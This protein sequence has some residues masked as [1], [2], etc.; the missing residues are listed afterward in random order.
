MTMLFFAALSVSCSEIYDNIKEFSVEEIVYPAHYDTIF[1]RPGY[2]R[3]EIDL[4]KEGRLPSWMMKLGKATKTIIEYDTVSLRYDSL[5]SW[6]N[7]TGLTQPKLYRFRIYTTDDNFEDRS[8]PL[9]IDIAPYSSFDRDALAV[10]TPNITTKSDFVA[11]NWNGGLTSEVME[12]RGLIYSYADKNGDSVNVRKWVE[13]EFYLTGLEK[14][15]ETSVNVRYWV[16]PKLDGENI[17]DSVYFDQEL[18]VTLED[19]ALIRF[20][21]SPAR[22]ALTPGRMKVATANIEYGLTWTSSNTNV[23]LVSSGGVITARNPGTAIITVRSEPV[24]YPATVEVTVTDVSSIPANGRLVGMWTFEDGNDLVKASVG[25]DLVA[26]GSSFTSTAGP[27]NTKAVKIGRNSY[28]AIQHEIAATGGS[29]VNEYTLM[30]DIRGSAEEFGN[31]LSVFNTKAGNEGDGVL[32]IDGDGKIGSAN[33]GGYSSEVL[34]PNIWQR[35]VI[36]AKLGGSFKVYINGSLAWS[37]SA[38][39]EADGLMSLLTDALYIGYD[40]KGGGYQGPE[41]AEIRIWN[42]SLT[43]AEIS[44]LGGAY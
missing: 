26:T 40:G 16:T 28:Y 44:T 21:A 24:D 29:N 5:F 25:N 20:A 39:T 36:S 9:P 37:A 3:V 6:I 19:S 41:F 13:P 2:E 22:M 32:W 7:I 11:I 23:A 4:S 17:L 34:R 10:P 30:M 42:T 12:F 1:G 8:T 38:G 14:G 33:L 27:I 43:D 15:K 31:W 18:L 35:V